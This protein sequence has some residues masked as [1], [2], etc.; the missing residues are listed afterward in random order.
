MGIGEQSL[1]GLTPAVLPKTWRVQGSEGLGH[2]IQALHLEGLRKGIWV[3]QK[4]VSS[5]CSKFKE[6]V[7]VIRTYSLS[8][9]L[10]WEELLIASNAMIELVKC[11]RVSR[12]YKQ[13]FVFEAL[14]Y[15][16]K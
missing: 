5:D 15:F 7:Q 1:E 14:S 3:R 10:W 11:L 2:E 16:S 12:N 6:S 9:S 4:R 13:D 8:G